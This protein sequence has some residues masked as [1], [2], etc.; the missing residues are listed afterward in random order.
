MSFQREYRAS[1]PQVKG[2]MDLY[3]W[4]CMLGCYRGLENGKSSI[5][6]LLR[7]MCGHRARPLQRMHSGRDS[8]LPGKEE[9]REPF[10]PGPEK[11][12]SVVCELAASG[13]LLQQHKHVRTNGT[14]DTETSP[15]DQ[16]LN[17]QNSRRKS[18]T[19]LLSSVTGSY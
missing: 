6:T 9:T 8:P 3:P 5:C 10:E 7:T 11:R 17:T 16:H 13:V 18:F 4:E 14:S 1:Q 15:R 19:G 12:M 2:I